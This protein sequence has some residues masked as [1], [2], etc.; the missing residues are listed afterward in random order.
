MSRKSK[1]VVVDLFCG[2]GGESQGIHWA[3]EKQDVEVEMYAVN[4]WERAIETHSANFPKDEC[5]CRD[6]A[7]IS[8]SRVVSGGHVSLLWASPACTHFSVAR[9]G[10]PMEEQS[11]V[12]PFTVLDWLDKLTVDRV[13][14]ENVPEFQSWGP[15]NADNRPNSEHKGATFDAF[16]AMIR[17]LGYYVDWRVMNAAD[18][19]APTT[20][21]RLFIQAVRQGCGKELLWPNQSHYKVQDQGNELFTQ[22]EDW[23]PASS[24]IDWTQ[25]RKGLLGRTKPL[26]DSTMQ[27]VADGIQKFWTPTQCE[28]FIARFNSGRNRVHSIHEP[29]PVLDCSNRYALVE[30]IV[31]GFY[32]NA[33]YTPISKPLPTLTTKERFALLEGYSI[34]GKAVQDVS[35]RMLTVDEI[36]RAQSFP[37][38]YR[39]SGNRADAVKQI[40][41]SVCPLIAEALAH[42]AFGQGR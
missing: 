30:P 12:T 23:V 17:S 1:E 10:K 31:M 18:Y 34:D 14:I 5:I 35:L 39:F 6:I 4:H 36:K 9:G 20:R 32:G 33:T 38:S 7:D 27:K 29:L 3:A 40:G 15:L 41:N 25:E 37:A 21:K 22:G 26:A 28:P 24:I 8:P 42:N 19:G 16:I 13:I 11:R 2:A